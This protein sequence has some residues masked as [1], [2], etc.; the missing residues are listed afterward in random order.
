MGTFDE[1][2]EAICAKSLN[3][4]GLTAKPICLLNINGFYDG[5][6][7][8]MQKSLEDSLLQFKSIDD[9]FYIAQNPEEAVQWCSQYIWDSLGTEIDNYSRI[10]SK[11]ATK[12]L[13][14]SN[15]KSYFRSL[16]WL[17]LGLTLGLTIGY[18]LK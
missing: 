14:E 1:M 3:M 2:C 11:I 4:K 17:L 6:I 15:S 18:K 12:D 9:Y 8:Q 5:F 10:K 13:L 16:S 7:M